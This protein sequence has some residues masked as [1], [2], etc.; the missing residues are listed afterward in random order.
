MTYYRI[1]LLGKRGYR[2]TR[3]KF[4]SYERAEEYRLKFYPLHTARITVELP[5]D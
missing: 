2:K 1:E 3:N 4:L 5:K